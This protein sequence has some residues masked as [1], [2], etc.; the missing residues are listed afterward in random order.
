LEKPK[1]DG[2]AESFHQIQM[3]NINMSKEG[4]LILGVLSAFL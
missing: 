4:F 2:L 3:P 1:K